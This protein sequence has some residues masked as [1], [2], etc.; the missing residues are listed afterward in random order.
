MDKK[1]KEENSKKFSG[2][3]KPLT[4]QDKADS[5]ES[6][7]HPSFE[8]IAIVN[9]DFSFRYVNPQWCEM[10]EQQ[11][12]EFL[13]K[14]FA[15]ITPPDIRE[16]DIRNA[17]LTINGQIPNYLMHK[18]Y[19]FMNGS[20]KDVVLLVARVPKDLSKPFRFFVSKIM[21]DQGECTE[22]DIE[23][24]ARGPSAWLALM[25]FSKAYGPMFIAIGGSIAGAIFYMLGIN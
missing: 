18:S 14:S 8:G 11:P 9:R 4:L 22:S 20:K 21:L 23:R 17:E 12:S 2:P 19:Q 6:S 1:T 10:L 16:L 13:N 25:E 15:D 7:W 5:W 3:S 24:H